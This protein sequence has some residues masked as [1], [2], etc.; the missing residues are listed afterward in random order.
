[1]IAEFKCKCGVRAE[2]DQDKGFVCGYCGSEMDLVWKKEWVGDI[3]T[4]QYIEWKQ[5]PKKEAGNK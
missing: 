2:T 4:G 5:E 3:Q 1:M